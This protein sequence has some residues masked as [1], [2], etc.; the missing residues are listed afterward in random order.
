MSISRDRKAAVIREFQRSPSDCGSCQVQVA[1]LTE[2]IRS[3]TDHLQSQRKDY[4]S[5]R[6]LLK[7]V[8][9]R[10]T[11][12]RYLARSDRAEYLK[13]IGSLGLRK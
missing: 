2:R 9:R 12:L 5:Q 4:A 6:G 8:G 10:N 7:M 1:L 3:I 11:L 13:L